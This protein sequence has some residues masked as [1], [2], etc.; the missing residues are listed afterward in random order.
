MKGRVLKKLFR[1]AGWIK[2]R[3]EGSH[4]QWGKGALR[5]TISAGDGDEIPK[6]T[7]G[8]LLKRLKE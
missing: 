7:L 8:K 6:K 3:Q 5:E 1:E 2:L 4:E